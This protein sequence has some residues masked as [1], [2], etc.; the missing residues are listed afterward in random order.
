MDVFHLPGEDLATYKPP[1]F[2]CVKN[3]SA[4]K[5]LIKYV[6]LPNSLLSISLAVMLEINDP[7]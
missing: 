3:F 1:S 2:D 5:P 7:G 6:M 4:P